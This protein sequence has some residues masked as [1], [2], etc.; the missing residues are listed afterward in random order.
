MQKRGREENDAA[1]A[2]EGAT[3]MQLLTSLA[4]LV[5]QIFFNYLRIDFLLSVAK[6]YS[7]RGNQSVHQR[8]NSPI[9]ALRKARSS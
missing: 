1:K 9:I 7:A 2:A 4:P 5:I 6:H 8:K 3:T